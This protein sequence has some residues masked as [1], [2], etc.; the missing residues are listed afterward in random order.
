MIA[1]SQLWDLYTEW[2]SL[3]ISEGLAIQAGNWLE[4]SR[5][6]AEK[7]KLQGRI[8]RATESAK[9]ECSSS[10]LEEINAGIRARVNELI[11]LE[12]RNNFTLQTSLAALEKE[13]ATLDQTSS[14]LRQVHRRYVPARGAAWNRYS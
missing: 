12:S 10:E 1:T 11:G 9:A 7:Q 8:I 2:K 6:Q 13:R 3:S 4:V 14:T 5:C